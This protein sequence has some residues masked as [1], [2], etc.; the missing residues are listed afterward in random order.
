MLGV[1]EQSGLYKTQNRGSTEARGLACTRGAGGPGQEPGGSRQNHLVMQKL[2]GGQDQ[3]RPR[4]GTKDV[5]I[6]WLTVRYCHLETESLKPFQCE[7][8]AISFSKPVYSV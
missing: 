2:T 1:T 5:F 7:L 3:G 4:N 8:Y 6:R